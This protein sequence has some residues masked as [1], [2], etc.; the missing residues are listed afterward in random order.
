MTEEEKEELT[1]KIIESV[2]P[3]FIGLP[4]HERRSMMYRVSVDMLTM[5]FTDLKDRDINELFDIFVGHMKH[6]I[7][8]ISKMNRQTV[9]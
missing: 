4:A 3:Y 5:S 6:R 2:A 9:H 1:H 7:K 8:E